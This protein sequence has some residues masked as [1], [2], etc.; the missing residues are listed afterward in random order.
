M[1][2]KLSRKSILWSMLILTFLLLPFFGGNYLV[3]L[4]NVGLIF[5]IFAM[6]YDLF[7]G[8][9]DLVSFGHSA[10]YGI[11]AYVVGIFSVTV[12]DIKNPVILIGLAIATGALLGLKVSAVATIP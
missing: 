4:F 1:K 12:F 2:S 9:T 3:Y 5:A 6:A 10:F 11:P 8:Y 7:Y